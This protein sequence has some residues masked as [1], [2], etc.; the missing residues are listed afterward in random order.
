LTRIFRAW[1]RP[2]RLAPT[3]L[4]LATSLLA[5]PG[6][7][8]AAAIHHHDEITTAVLEE[9]GWSDENAIAIVSH[10]NMATDFAR[11][12]GYSRAT[13][14]FVMPATGTYVPLVRQLGET[15]PF[16]PR[17]TVGHHFNSLYSY[18]EIAARWREM[19]EWVEG[20][21]SAIAALDEPERNRMALCLLGIVTHAVQDFYTHANW[22][23]ILNEYTPGDMVAEQ[24]P[25]WE[26]FHDPDGDWRMRNLQIPVEEVLERLKISNHELSGDE[27]EGGLQT[28][29]VRG[30]KFDGPEPWSHR[31]SRGA[32]QVVVHALAGRA[33][34]IWVARIEGLL[35]GSDEWI[36]KDSATADD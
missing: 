18:D 31:H 32:E 36:A 28:G 8:Q 7:A 19:E 16:S 25:L 11:L 14:D 22:V 17:A 26:E 13:L 35:G 30:E 9:M 33:T 24:F 34:K 10:C 3:V 29:S 15:A 27:H 2:A 21:C 20:A 1:L 6:V 4:L 12:P 5:T 23:G